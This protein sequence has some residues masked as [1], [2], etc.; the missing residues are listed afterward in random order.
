MS[1]RPTTPQLG[2]NSFTC[3]H[4][5]AIAHQTW[6]RLFLVSYEKGN[7]PS[8]PALEVIG[9]I[10]HDRNVPNKASKI[11]YFEKKLAKILFLRLHKEHTY[12]KSE[13][14]NLYTSLCYSCGQF[15]IWVADDLIYPLQKIAI[16]PN[17]DMPSEIRTDFIEAAAIV[18][19][20]PRGAAALLRLCIQKLMVFLK[21]KG[22]N[23]D[24]DIGAL[25]KQGLDSRIQKAL[26]VVRVIGN[27]AVHPGQIDLRDDKATA[28]KL[29]DLVNL[30]VEAMI[31]TP[32]HIEEMYRALPEN[33]RKA[34]EKRDGKP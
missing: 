22:K 3:P 20:S 5:G 21:Q 12:T 9:I 34:I 7:A 6:Y 25:V 32:K 15:A 31:S 23:I 33:A 4:C 17:Q 13:L 10:E 8:M 19:Q 30:I 18:D 2:A 16:Q 26:D 1:G 14:E 28:M 27:N 29:F 24:D 11:E